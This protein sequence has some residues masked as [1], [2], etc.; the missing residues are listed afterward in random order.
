MVLYVDIIGLCNSVAILWLIYVMRHTWLR[1]EITSIWSKCSLRDLVKRLWPDLCIITLPELDQ[2][3]SFCV[4]VGSPTL[5]R[6]VINKFIKKIVWYKISWKWKKNAKVR[7]S[8]GNCA[9]QNPKVWRNTISS[10]KGKNYWLRNEVIVF[11]PRDFTL[12]FFQ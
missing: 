6:K 8:K 2:Q 1:G 12:Y 11:S 3:S 4:S 7:D 10:P 9:F 5:T